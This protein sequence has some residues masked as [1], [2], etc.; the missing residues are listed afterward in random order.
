MNS[1]TVITSMQCGRRDCGS[2]T[3]KLIILIALAVLV[4]LAFKM[5]GLGDYFSKEYIEQLLERLGAWA[6]AGFISIYAIATILGVPGTIL[7]ILGGVLFGSYWGT[8]LI[9]IGATIGACGAFFVS[10]FLARGFI[11][12][13]FGSASWF[14][15]L[16]DGIEEQGFFYILFIRLVP[17]FPF[18]GINFASGLTNIKFRDY[19]LAT[20]IGIIP[21][22]FVYANAA[23]QA[24]EAA[25]E[26]K[27]GAG[28]YISFALLG[29]LA[30]VPVIYK[31]Y[32]TKKNLPLA[33]EDS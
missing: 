31:K 33:D 20:A 22:A 12:E 11:S 6:P 8:L 16:D 28:L 9:V 4:I 14:K 5:F 24:A 10:R 13:K 2:A 30:L 32:K 29:M 23:S 7:T 1:T 15:K 27:T 18:N 3:T 17:L 21:G 26:G 19:A 25:A